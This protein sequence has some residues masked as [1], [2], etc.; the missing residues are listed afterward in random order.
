M[1]P[2]WVRVEV[3]RGDPANGRTTAAAKIR[4]SALEIRACALTLSSGFP[5]IAAVNTNLAETPPLSPNRLA[6]REAIVTAAVEVLRAEGLAGCTSRAIAEASGFAKSALH[7]YFR[8]TEEIVDQ[9]FQR[10]MTQFVERIGQAAAAAPTPDA[11]LW[12]AART[13]LHLGAGQHLGH[14]PMLWFEVHLAASRMGDTAT[15]Q[16]ITDAVRERFAALVAATGAGAPEATA[17]VLFSCM[18]GT[19]VRDA[20]AP[21]D[22][23]AELDAAFTS[24]GLRR[25]DDAAS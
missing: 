2:P 5:I 8:D 9:A 23:D 19:L 13:Y 11:A 12:A 10:L 21:L 17:R 3:P 14:G 16:A 1:S 24:L 7:Y 25:P 18:I 20:M 6:K 4:A 15:L 22:L